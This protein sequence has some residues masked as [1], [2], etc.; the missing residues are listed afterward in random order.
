M[1][2]TGATESV[3]GV[4]SMACVLDSCPA[5][6]YIQLEDRP[7][8]RLRR[9]ST[10]SVQD[11]PVPLPAISSHRLKSRPRRLKNLS[12]RSPC[13]QVLKC[14]ESSTRHRDPCQPWDRLLDVLGQLDLA[15]AGVE[16]VARQVVDPLP[17]ESLFFEDLRQGRLLCTGNLPSRHS[18][19]PDHFGLG[20]L[21][22]FVR[23]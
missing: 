13:S 14:R 19:R 9:Q 22:P 21:L 18:I 16:V 6:Y 4:E 8:F 12:I 23:I 1:L 7:R 11:L 15:D 20:G 5:L 3:A 10:S 2:Y 17:T